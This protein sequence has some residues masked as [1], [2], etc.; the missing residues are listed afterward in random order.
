MLDIDAEFRKGILFVRLHGSL[1]KNTCTFLDAYLEPMISKK[2]VR[3]VVFNF[4]N[5]RDI[6]MAGINALLKYNTNLLKNEGKAVIC[7]LKNEIVKWR[8]N[9]SRM[10]NYMF[11]TSN[12]LS[13]INI[14][15]M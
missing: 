13:A 4:D 11:E 1:D 2:D 3:Y 9:N 6:D 5:L 10:L 14:I 12:E 7:N 15:N 8:I